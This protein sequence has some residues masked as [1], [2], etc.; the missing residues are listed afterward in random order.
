MKIANILLDL[1]GTLV[2]SWPGI[3]YASQV[4]VRATLPGKVMPELRPYM[5]PP[6]REMFRQALQEESVEVIIELER[7]FRA[8]YDGEGWRRS[9]A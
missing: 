3:E 7:Q 2:D 5:G 8:S 6:I 9:V 4:A 1:D